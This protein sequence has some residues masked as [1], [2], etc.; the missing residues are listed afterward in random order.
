MTELLESISMLSG[1]LTA[2]EKKVVKLMLSKNMMSGRVNN[3]DY[4]LTDIGDGKWEVVLKYMDRG[5]I[6]VPGTKLRLSTYR[7]VIRVK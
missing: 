6:P 2:T 4:F 3:K 5:L 7:S 1:H